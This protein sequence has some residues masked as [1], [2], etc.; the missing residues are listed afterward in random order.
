VAIFAEIAR[1][2]LWKPSPP[3]SLMVYCG[4]RELCPWMDEPSSQKKRPQKIALV[5]LWARL[6][7]IHLHQ[8]SDGSLS[9]FLAFPEWPAKKSNIPSGLGKVSPRKEIRFWTLIQY[10]GRLTWKYISLQQETTIFFYVHVYL[11]LCFVNLCHVFYVYLVRCSG[12]ALCDRENY[13]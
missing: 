5:V 6:C 3:R 10:F 11:F 2:C 4:L 13:F 12:L 8:P 9:F 1:A 7:N